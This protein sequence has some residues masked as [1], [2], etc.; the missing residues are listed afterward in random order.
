MVDEVLANTATV[1]RCRRTR[2]KIVALVVDLRLVAIDTVVDEKV[3]KAAW[4]ELECVYNH[5]RDI[6]EEK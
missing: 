3:S 5:L 6:M 2:E 1:C 4:E